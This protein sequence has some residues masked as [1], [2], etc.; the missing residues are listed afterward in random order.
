MNLRR[1]TQH[2][3]LRF[4]EIRNASIPYLHTPIAFTDEQVGKWFPTA[5]PYYVIELDGEMIGYFR[6]SHWKCESV[7]I[8]ADLAPEYR[9]R[10]IGTA[11]YLS[12]FQL[13]KALGIKKVW[14]KVL[15]TNLRA[16]HLYKKLEF[17]IIEE[18][19]VDIVMERIIKIDE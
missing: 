16:I 7:C 10:G 2:D 12:F 17:N 5:P 18:N 11:T 1:M 9:N 3:L 14:L 8:G 15:T 13:L 4:N 19:E 6:T